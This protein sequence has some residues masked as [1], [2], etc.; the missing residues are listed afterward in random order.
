[1]KI[2]RVY[3]ITID[4]R[5]EYYQELLERARNLPLPE[6][7]PIQIMSGFVGK[8][9]KTEKNLPYKTYSGWDLTYR[10]NTNFWWTRPVT[11]GEAGGCI[12]HTLCWEDA[13][14]NGYERIM[15][16]ED[17]FTLLEPIDWK[18]FKEMDGY[19]WDICLMSHNSLHDLFLDVPRPYMIGREHFFRPTYFYNTHTYILNSEGI[20]KLVE[21]HLS[22]LKNNVIV[23]D[24]FLSAVTTSHP[25]WDIRGLF[26]SNMIAIATK[27]NY[28]GQSRSEGLGNSLT[29]PDNEL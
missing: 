27:K 26:I 16:L 22:S 23:S 14:E 2:D 13:Y 19:D 7:T 20:R 8:R 28:T 10:G 12:S 29:E 11:E 6:G 15:I 5:E 9:L 1:M 25:R 3:I 21:D 4:H 17:D 18:I 24:E